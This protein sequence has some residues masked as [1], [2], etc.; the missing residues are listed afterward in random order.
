M[1]GLSRC[2]AGAFAISLG[3]GVAQASD[4]DDV[5]KA[6]DGLASNVEY[7]DDYIQ[8]VS[9]AA[10]TALSGHLD[11]REHTVVVVDRSPAKQALFVFYVQPDDGW[12]TLYSGHVSTGKPGR[13]E[14]FKTP[15]GV[16]VLD[17][18]I[19]DYRAQGTFNE[20]HIRGIGL[21]GSRVWD[22]GWQETDDWRTP[23]AKMK[24]RMEMHATDPANLEH[25]IGRADSEGCIRIHAD[26]NKVLDKYG[27]LDRE[28]NQ[29]AQNGSAGWKQVL[30]KEHKYSDISGDTLVIVDTSQR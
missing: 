22:F 24:I 9:N 2:L 4:L 7:P 8:S 21:K 19:M 10:S 26:L 16:F 29:L 23:G 27:I 17:G 5:S 6:F 11:I 15:T 12:E 13:K 1:S 30:G 18:S 25:R 14:H 3:L 20:N 28:P